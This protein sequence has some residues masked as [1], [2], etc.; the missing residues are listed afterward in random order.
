MSK[1]KAFFQTRGPGFYLT[2]VASVLSLIEAIVYVAFYTQPSRIMYMSWAA[3]W[4]PFV[5]VAVCAAL[6]VFRWT[7]E[8]A[9]FALFGVEFGAFFAYIGGCY[10][11]LSTT[12]FGGISLDAFLALDAGFLSCT[13]LFVLILVL[14]VV[15]VFQL[16][17][18]KERTPREKAKKA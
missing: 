15:A 17:T 10:L 18:R 4:L 7:Q 13:L 5:A 3:F 14:S 12:F 9:P 2:A 16:Q 8:L 11:S 6:S 1:V